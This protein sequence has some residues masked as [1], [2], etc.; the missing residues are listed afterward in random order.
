MKKGCR[1]R[2]P[3][4]VWGYGNSILPC[5]CRGRGPR[6]EGARW[7]GGLEEPLGLGL[8]DGG[9]RPSGAPLHHSPP[10]RSGERSP[11]TKVGEE[12]LSV[13]RRIRIGRIV[14]LS[15]QRIGLVVQRRDRGIGAVLGLRLDFLVAL[16]ERAGGVFG[17]ELDIL[18]LRI[19][20]GGE[21]RQKGARKQHGDSVSHRAFRA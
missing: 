21:R 9:E 7:R 17:A 19:L 18:L 15:K 10:L 2:Q 20:A 12:L 16:L 11:S 14:Q 8:A 3:F 6:A 5:V 4:D 1:Q 13:H